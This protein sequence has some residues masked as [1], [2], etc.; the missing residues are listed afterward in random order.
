MRENDREMRGRVRQKE[1]GETV[2]KMVKRQRESVREKKVF[3]TFD[4]TN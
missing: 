3:K 2:T 4:T 1:R